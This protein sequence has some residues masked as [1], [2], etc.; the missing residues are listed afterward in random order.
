MTLW[1]FILSIAILA[2]TF[3]ASFKSLARERS[4]VIL[5]MSA[6]L[7]HFG[8]SMLISSVWGEFGATT[9][10]LRVL[11]A[12]AFTGSGAL[13]LRTFFQRTPRNKEE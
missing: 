12:A 8:I 6:V 10:P 2:V 9:A 3:V 13:W 11:T 4:L 7:F 1:W 5:G